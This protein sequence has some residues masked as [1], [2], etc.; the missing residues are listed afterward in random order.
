MEAKRAESFASRA[1]KPEPGKH[2][3]KA[4]RQHRT[5]PGGGERRPCPVQMQKTI[6]TKKQARIQQIAERLASL[7]ALT[8]TAT[9][10]A[11]GT[12]SGTSK[13]AKRRKKKAAA[14]ALKAAPATVAS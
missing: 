9:T 2:N 1:A 4:I 12:L 10:E 13:A 11:V 3:R 6:S 7:D 5:G 14:A 8:E